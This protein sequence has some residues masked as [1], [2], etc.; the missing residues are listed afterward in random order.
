M[1]QQEETAS[2]LGWNT[3]SE[4]SVT[5]RQEQFN[6]VLGKHALTI[7]G[8]DSDV[9]I[10][11]KTQERI[12]T[13]FL[14]QNH[15]SAYLQSEI[16]DSTPLSDI[17]KIDQVYRNTIRAFGSH[18]IR[19]NFI[20]YD[21]GRSTKY[22]FLLDSQNPYTLVSRETAV[23]ESSSLSDRRKN[24][25][26]KQLKHLEEFYYGSDEHEFSKK[27][28]AGMIATGGIIVVGGASYLS[29]RKIHSK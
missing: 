24:K 12:F 5:C 22:A 4:L 17:D 10:P 8:D 23:I 6:L 14:L 25:R 3:Y 26:L 29:Y 21:R 28:L 2:H 7:I 18:M 9:S 15:D 20:K 13:R 1:S 16:K 27:K 11:L 19:D